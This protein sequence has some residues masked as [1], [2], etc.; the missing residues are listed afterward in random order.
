MKDS[1]KICPFSFASSRE[2][3]EYCLTEKCQIWEPFTGMCSLAVVGFLA[4]REAALK[5]KQ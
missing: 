2:D 5:E 1:K 3:V 4:G